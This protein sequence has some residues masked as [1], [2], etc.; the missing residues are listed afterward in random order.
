MLG[1]KAEGDPAH[2]TT[3]AETV[4]GEPGL[5]QS[6]LPA[7]PNTGTTVIAARMREP[8][9]GTTWH[10]A[11]VGASAGVHSRTNVPPRAID[12]SLSTVC[13][14]ESGAAGN[15]ACLGASVNAPA[16]R[17]AARAS[18]RTS[19]HEHVAECAPASDTH[20]PAVDG[21]AGETLAARTV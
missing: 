1:T 11:S 16:M 15:A 18:S 17:A 4:V 19:S 12:A 2:A 3:R 20:E 6:Y 13:R 10:V 9:Y 7:C 8:G 14:A 5:V 21:S